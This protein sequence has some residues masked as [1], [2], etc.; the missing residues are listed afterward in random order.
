MN[1][2]A[3]HRTASPCGQWTLNN[4]KA[5]SY[6]MDSPPPGN[7]QATIGNTRVTLRW[8][9]PD[10][11][12]ITG[13]QYRVSDDD[14]N[15]WN[16][17]WTDV[18]SSNANTTSHTVRD[19]TNGVPYTFQ[20]RALRGAK[21]SLPSQIDATPLGPPTA[22]GTPTDLG[23]AHRDGALSA[24]WTRPKEDSRAPVTSYPVRYRRAGSS[25]SWTNVSRSGPDDRTSQLI[26]GLTNRRHYEV[27]VAA[28]K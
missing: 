12:D 25:A 13:Y 20:L 19:L 5:Y 3:L 8:S 7:L 26:T 17:D 16:P 10:D 14:G 11:N 4:D 1:H 6:N 24:S 22:P 9:N 23:L 15:T 28:V 21:T 27:Q 18:P 2:A